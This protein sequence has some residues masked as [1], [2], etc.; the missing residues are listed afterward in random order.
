MVLTGS[1]GFTLGEAQRLG[2]LICREFEF[3]LV[4]G[5]GIRDHDCRHDAQEHYHNAEF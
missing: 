5:G 4:T 3:S 2:Y 1:Q